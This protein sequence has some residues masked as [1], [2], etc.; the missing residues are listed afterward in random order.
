MRRRRSRPNPTGGVPTA[1][2]VLGGLAVLGGVGYWLYTQQ[3]GEEAN[4]TSPSQSTILGPGGSNVT[5][6]QTASTTSLA[7]SQAATTSAAPAYG[8]NS[9]T[10]GGPAGFTF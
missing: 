9:G 10:P 5:L 1:V 2:Y 8:V 4:A 7:P 3:E 6:P